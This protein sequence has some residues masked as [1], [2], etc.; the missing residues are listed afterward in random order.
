MTTPQTGTPQTGTQQR[1]YW[2][3]ELIAKVR[4]DTPGTE[5]VIHFNNAG[6]SL[7]PQAVHDAMVG[8]LEREMLTGGYEAA[9]EAQPA[10]DAMYTS[11]AELL[12]CEADD[13]GVV[14]SAT[15]AWSSALSAIQF[16]PG[17]KILTAESEYV[18][19]AMGL[20]R[21]IDRWGIEV[22]VA[23]SDASGQVD[24]DA[25]AS[26]IDDRTTVI[27]LTHVPTQG[28]LVQPA[29]A[30]GQVA[31]D[32]GVMFMLDACQSVGQLRVDVD[33][34]NADI[35]TFTGRKFL[36]AP[37]GCGMIY[38]RPETLE[39]LGSHV[40]LDA[41]SSDWSSPWEID[42]TP[43][44]R[45]FTP[46]E[47]TIAAKVG[48]GVAFDYLNVLGIDQVEQRVV[49]LAGTMRTRLDEIDHI[50]VHDLGTY[51]CGIVTF[52]ST[53]HSAVEMKSILAKRRIN[54]S[55]TSAESAQFDLP[56]RGISEMVRASAHYF[57]TDDEID[58]LIAA[59]S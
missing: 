25:L 32:A 21:G 7:P 59:L 46:F 53:R 44:T 6:S 51:R 45:R 10:V 23:P 11:A 9:A 43:K 12:G 5:Q 34:L 50:T 58:Q 15:R 30:V 33:E 40:G 22:D 42:L 20:L 41:G 48:M 13:L 36:R 2:T 49:E 47:M 14:E 35:C 54:V 29:A 56:K 24:V 31:R 17:D 3:N 37:R 8:H 16:K 27:A 52:N 57:N 4:A 1:S 19:N 28:G 26:M 18:S 55:V 38:V 39:K